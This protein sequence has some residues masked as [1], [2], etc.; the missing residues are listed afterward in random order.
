MT[1]NL[2]EKIVV[3]LCAVVDYVTHAGDL[4]KVT[5]TRKMVL[6]AGSAKTA[7]DNHLKEERREKRQ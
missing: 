6:A 2:K 3:A 1:N 4:D 7:Y 5:I